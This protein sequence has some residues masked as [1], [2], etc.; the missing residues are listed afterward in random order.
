MLR[1]PRVLV[2]VFCQAFG[3]LAELLKQAR[4]HHGGYCGENTR[5]FRVL[6]A[7]VDEYMER[8]WTDYKN[9]TMRTQCSMM[10][11]A[12]PKYAGLR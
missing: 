3:T 2:L 11:R 4:L 12:A 1:A 7:Q 10:K 6:S 5:A 8:P 9:L